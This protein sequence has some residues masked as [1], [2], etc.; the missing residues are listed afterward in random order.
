MDPG[1]VFM[2]PGGFLSSLM[3]P[4]WF[5]SELSGA[6]VKWDVKNTEK[7]LT[8]SVSWPHN[9]ASDDDDD[10]EAAKGHGPVVT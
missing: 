4:G 1:L 10:D 3:V 9:P 8:S 7:V 5:E 6:G 2:I